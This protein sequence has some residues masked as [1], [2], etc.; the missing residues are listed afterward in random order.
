MAHRSG[1]VIPTRQPKNG[2]YGSGVSGVT[3][4]IDSCARRGMW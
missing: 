1:R 3:Q 4:A 2:S